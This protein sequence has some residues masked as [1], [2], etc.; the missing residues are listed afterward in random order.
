V[1]LRFISDSF[2]DMNSPLVS[3]VMPVFNAEKYLS[4]TINSVLSQTFSDFELII[5]DDCSTDGSFKLAHAYESDPR[6]RALRLEANSGGPARPRNF[7]LKECRG[8]YI[9]FVDSDDLWHPRKLEL[10]VALMESK[11]IFMISTSFQAIGDH[12]TYEE[13]VKER[14]TVGDLVDLPMAL[15]SQISYERLLIDNLIPNSSAFVRSDAIKLFSFEEG[16]KYAAV[17]DYIMWC[18][19]HREFGFSMKL[20]LPL[21]AYRYSS[22]SISR[23]KFS[24]LLKRYSALRL[25][26]GNYFHIALSMFGYIFNA[27]FRRLKMRLTTQSSIGL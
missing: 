1:S 19:L 2:S 3:V 17:E 5:I 25:L 8:K 18:R 10:Q 24:M 22:A 15:D 13:Y 11:S 20:M 26:T 14:F 16:R 9:A 4:D 21:F 7:G 12:V 6:V 27:F 23:H